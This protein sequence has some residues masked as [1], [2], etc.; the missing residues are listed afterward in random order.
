M[1]F[2][3]LHILNEMLKADFLDQ[4]IYTVKEIIKAELNFLLI[5]P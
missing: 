2:L 1:H 5:F 4:K 3:I